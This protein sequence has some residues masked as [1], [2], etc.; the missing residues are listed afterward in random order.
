MEIRRILC[1]NVAGKAG[2]TQLAQKDITEKALVWY[3]DVFSDIV[4]N[5]LF[6]GKDVVSPDALQNAVTH[7]PYKSDSRKV[8]AQDRDSCKLWIDQKTEIRLSYFGIENE[9][10][11]E[12][13]MPFRV[14]GYD[15]A[16]YRDQICD[17]TGENK[18][19]V[20]N[21]E[22]YPV[23]TLVLY[24]GYKKHWDKAKTL[25]EGFTRPVP[26]LL[27]P[28][29]WN[30][31]INLFEIAY[32]TDEQVNCFHSDFWIVADYFT[33]M[34]KNNNYV[35]SERQLIHVRE[36]LDLMR[37]LT[38]DERFTEHVDEFEKSKEAVTMC[39]VLDE[40]ENRGFRNGEQR[41]EQN[42]KNQM[43]L[44]MVKDG[45]EPEKIAKYAEVTTEY[46]FKIKDGELQMV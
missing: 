24:M 45:L 42:A 4:N 35:P 12:D 36:V 28:Y 39:A 44:N 2:E 29:V 8:R 17:Y 37:V 21:K 15:G 5:L 10:E 33:Q 40:V 30:Y 6:D 46:V 34:R 20:K 11:A 27:K 9:T 22:R 19:R 25:Y 41:G 13:D 3:N 14:I 31:G 32:L 38:G 26:E 43:I 18:N 23:V 7:L 16:A 1:Y